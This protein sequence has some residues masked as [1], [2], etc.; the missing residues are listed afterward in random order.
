[1]RYDAH[2]NRSS[3]VPGRV[4]RAA[5]HWGRAFGDLLAVFKNWGAEASLNLQVAT[6]STV[7]D[8]LTGA[9]GI[10][11]SIKAGAAAV[12]LIQAS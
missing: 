1:M 7:T 8:L 12:L 2:W 10:P 6:G 4:G 5:A 9:R 11:A 3:R